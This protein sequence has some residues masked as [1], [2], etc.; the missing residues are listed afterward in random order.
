VKKNCLHLANELIRH[1]YSVM[2]G[3]TDNHLLLL[4]VRPQGLTGS[5]VEEVC[6]LAHLY[7]NKNTVAGDVSALSPGGVRIGSACMS[8]RNLKVEDFT[9]IA[10]FLHR[11][12]QLALVAQAKYGKGIQDFKKGIQKEEEIFQLRKEVNAF[13][14]SFPIPGN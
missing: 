7:V 10:E 12:I 6:N 11:A 2:T 3:G 4:D 1:G 5:K 13:A 9:R 14:S 8:S